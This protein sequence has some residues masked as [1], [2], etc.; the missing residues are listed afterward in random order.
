VGGIDATGNALASAELVTA[1]GSTTAP[2]LATARVGHTATRLNNGK[3]LVT[4][5]QASAQS[6]TVFTSSEL[7]DPVAG[8]FAPGPTL[9][10]GRSEAI[11]VEFGTNGNMSVLIAGGSNG[12]TPLATAEIYDEATNTSTA[13]SGSMVEAHAGAMAALMDDGTVLIVGGLALTG[14][15][16]AEVFNPATN[17]FSAISMS[18]NRSGA[19]FASTG[20]EAVVAGGQSAT[21]VGSSTEDYAIATKTFATGASLSTARTNAT[22][23][24]LNG[25]S[26][27]F[28]GGLDSSGA[29]GTCELLSGSTIASGTMSAAGSL[30]TARFGH[31]ATTLA[32]GEVLV[33]GGFSASGVVTASIETFTPSVPTT[34]PPATTTAP[35]GGSSFL[36]GILGSLLGGLTGSGGSGLG[37]LIQTLLGGGTGQGGLGSILSSLAGSA[38]GSLTG[39]STLGSI[40]SGILGGLTGS[41]GGS[42][43]SGIISSVLGAFTG[44]GGIGSLLGSIFG[45][46]SSASITGVTPPSA[47]VGTTVTLVITFSGL[48]TVN[49]VTVGSLTCTNI[50]AASSSLTC[51]L[52]IPAAPAS[53]GGQTVTLTDSSGN[54]ATLANGFTIN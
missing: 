2:H 37:S 23:S 22:A 29:I 45:G 4:G 50:Q 10:S 42:G 15:A 49:K 9:T 35:S 38:I 53:I 54:T 32:S 24:V 52:A 6:T 13:V 12:T 20:S 33:V 21:G 30:Q 44:G 26:V 34:P 18:T 39:S 28:V 36:G 11:A 46:G 5:G 43:L 25:T 51:T 8:S 17:T 40:A 27:V 41:G 16:G 31:T 19:A 47:N 1:S 3:V 7:Y 48:G 14:P